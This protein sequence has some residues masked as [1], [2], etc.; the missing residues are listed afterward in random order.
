MTNKGAKRR[1]GDF[2]MRFLKFP[3]DNL[4]KI[5]YNVFSKEKG[6]TNR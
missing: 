6:D 1:P 4:G 2:L 3:L 5:W